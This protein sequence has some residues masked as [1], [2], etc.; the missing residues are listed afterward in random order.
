MS[1]LERKIEWVRSAALESGTDPELNTLIQE[2]RPSRDARAAAEELA[3]EWG[4]DPDEVRDCP[5]ALLGSV[6]EIVDR[7]LEL[8][9]R[10]GLSYV[11]VFEDAMEAFAPALAALAGR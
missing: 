1:S 9:E 4:R 7:L 6:N 5:Y 10:H 11:T 8:R 2:V 3:P